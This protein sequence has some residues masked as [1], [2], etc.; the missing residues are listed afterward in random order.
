VR[1]PSATPSRYAVLYVHGYID[2]FFQHELARRIVAR[3]MNFYAVDLRKYGRSLRPYQTP[4][5]CT[6]IEDYFADLDAAMQVMLEEDGNTHVTIIAHSTGGLIASLYAQHRRERLPLTGLIL[7]SPFFDFNA[8]W[9]LK[10]GAIP[11]ACVIGRLAPKAAVPLPS[12]HLYG[13]SLHVA[14]RGEW[15]YNVAW[16]PVEGVSLRLGWLN[17]IRRAHQELHRGLAIA[18]PVLVLS[19]TRSFRPT[20][21]TD[22]IQHADIVLDVDDISRYAVVL[23]NHVTRVKIEG[24]MHDLL[25][26]REPVRERAYETLFTWLDT[27]ARPSVR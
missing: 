14:H 13:Q 22:D 6:R 4:Y 16:K 12:G 19:S 5:F 3:G 25:L 10:Y 2:Y 26:S 7:N 20:H 8:P 1:K 11:M 23:G 21:W 15:E 18:C 27:Y 9:L 17:A 24:G